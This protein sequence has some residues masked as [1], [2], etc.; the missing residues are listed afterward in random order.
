MPKYL[1]SEFGANTELIGGIYGQGIP[2]PLV[3][4]HD[5][6]FKP[7]DVKILGKDQRT[8]KL[9][10]DGIAFMW[11]MVT[12]ADKEL[13]TTGGEKKLELVGTMN[14][15]EWNGYKTNQIKVDKFEVSDYTLNLSDIF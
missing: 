3:H 14:I 6:R 11:F 4:I 9:E 13:L 5:I 1:F 2:E 12:N 7:S 8:L 15:N 10:K